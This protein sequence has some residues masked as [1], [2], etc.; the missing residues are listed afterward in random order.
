MRLDEETLMSIDKWRSRQ[1]GLPSRAEAIRQLVESGLERFAPEVVTL[2]PGEKLVIAM[3]ADLYKHLGVEGDIDAPLVMKT[4][5]G[6]HNWALTWQATHLPSG[7]FN[8]RADKK[9]D[10]DF[11]ID[12]LDMWDFIEYAYQGLPEKEKERI[13]KEV[14]GPLGKHVKFRGF[15]V[16][17][18]GDGPLYSIARFVVEDLERFTSTFR[19][20]DFN[21]HFPMAETY[22]RMLTVFEP[23]RKTLLG[24]DP[25]NTEQ[26]IRI[27]KAA[28]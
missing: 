6:G 13:A 23:I 4:I 10:V 2:S 27:L 9:E 15:D 26:L 5:L 11:V 18:G 20:R 28:K 12:V 22:R 8:I 16:N 14:D 17:H 25:L 24:T 19:D 3:L 21:S 1:T 7:L